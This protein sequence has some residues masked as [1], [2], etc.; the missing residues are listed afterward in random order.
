MAKVVGHSFMYILAICT[1][2]FENSLFNSCAHL[3]SGLFFLF[4]IFGGLYLLCHWITGKTFSSSVGCLLNLVSL[5]CDLQNF[6]RIWCSLI[7]QFLL[8]FP[9]WSKFSLQSQSLRWFLYQEFSVCFPV[10]VSKSQGS[11]SSLWITW[12]D[13]S[14]VWETGSYCQSSRC[15]YP[16]LLTLF[17][18][19]TIFSPM[20]IFSTFVEDQVA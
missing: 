14:I 7:C 16:V 18:E 4:A 12:S 8:L 11:H 15:R 10:A 1:S 2:S 5:S 19:D 13:F 17:V 3:L 20:F 9:E 6:L